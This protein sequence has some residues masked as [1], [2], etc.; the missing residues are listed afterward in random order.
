VSYWD[1]RSTAEH[2]AL[3]RGE[4]PPGLL[5]ESELLVLAD[6]RVPKRRRDWILGRYTAKALVRAWLAR[7]GRDVPA[8]MLTVVAGLD[9]APGVFLAGQGPLPITISLSHSGPF[10]LC[11]LVPAPL[12]Y[13]GADVEK[14]EPR[15]AG[16]L[17]DFFTPAEAAL[18]AA[19]P[20]AERDRAVTEMWSV[21]EAALKAVRL[22]LR[23]DT[24][25][26][27]VRPRA[28]RG[29]SWGRAEMRIDLPG[30][31]GGAAFVRDEGGYVASI[32]WLG[33]NSPAPSGE[34]RG[35]PV[36]PALPKP[37]EPRPEPTRPEE[38]MPAITL[39]G[40]A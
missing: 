27:V 4:P 21:K 19:L 5:S 2:P 36:L 10:A 24:R 12:A 16:F 40:A 29:A 26:V 28:W 8:T 23:A 3:E 13:L 25:E 32:A 7:T 9:G 38:A 39:G 31:A 37:E 35:H 18:V 6:L 11:A 17:A 22:G 34:L 14:C 1:L 20:R 33:G 15:P 30:A